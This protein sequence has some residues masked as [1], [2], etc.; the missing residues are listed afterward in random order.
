[1]M[2]SDIGMHRDVA[3]EGVAWEDL[4]VLLG[5][6]RTGS[7]NQAARGLRIGQSTAS[8]RLA[9]LEQRVG[10]RLFDRTPEGMLPNDLA[11]QLVPHAELVEMH[12]AD[13]ERVIEQREVEPR[14]RLRVALPE[15]LATAWLLPR[16]DG[17]FELYPHVEID[18]V[19]GNAVVDLVRREAD[20]AVRFVRPAT[21]DLIARHLG[22]LPLAAYA[23]PRVL[24]TPADT[25]RWIV[26]DDPEGVYQ[27][28]T[29]LKTHVGPRR[30]M[31]VSSWNALFAAARLG[32]GPA[33]LAPLVARPAGLVPVPGDLPA[34]P[35]RSLHLVVH[36]SLRKVPR[37]EV[38][39]NWLLE[40]APRFLT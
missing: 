15:G 11:A 27:E 18:F 12:M 36:R 37:I 31:R 5:V 17:F 40:H 9:R 39:R 21:G 23:H 35:E 38:F 28:S 20:V 32:L 22:V 6:V 26:L 3:I 8:R 14:G 19:I 16:I 4:L 2:L 7:L 33:I 30:T 24:E 1:M 13:I 34:I 10:A 29:W 25:W